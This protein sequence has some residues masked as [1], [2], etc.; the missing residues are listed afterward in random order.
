MDLLES[1]S[2]IIKMLKDDQYKDKYDKNHLLV[3]F[4]MYN[5]A[6]GII[7]LCEELN[8]REELLNFY[9]SNKEANKIIELCNLH[10]KTET[11]LWV[12][13]LKYFAK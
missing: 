9:I 1:E 12:Q 13:A 6:P 4:K 11:N 2:Q 7:H 10:G 8:L 5:F 3:L